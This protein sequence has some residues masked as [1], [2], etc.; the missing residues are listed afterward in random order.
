M[1]SSLLLVLRIVRSHKGSIRLCGL[2]ETVERVITLAKLDRVFDVHRT[3]AV[4]PALLSSVAEAQELVG[5]PLAELSAPAVIERDAAVFGRIL[6]GETVFDYETRH[7][8]RDGTPVDVSFNA[9][10]LR[11]ANGA[12]VGNYL[13]AAFSGRVSLGRLIT[14]SCLSAAALQALLYFSTG[15]YIFA[16]IRGNTFDGHDFLPSARTSA[17]P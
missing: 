17:L 8:R 16:A 14:I 15:V 6:G 7:V 11:D 1:V 4:T 9:I 2:G 5:R 12:I 13:M 10:P 3:L